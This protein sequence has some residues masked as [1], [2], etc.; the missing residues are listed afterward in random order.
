MTNIRHSRR[1]CLPQIRALGHTVVALRLLTAS[2]G[3]SADARGGK[4]RLVEGISGGCSSSDMA[5]CCHFFTS[6][7]KLL[8]VVPFSCPFKLRLRLQK[9]ELLSLRKDGMRSMMLSAL[10]ILPRSRMIRFQSLMAVCMWVCECINL[11]EEA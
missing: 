5:S 7:Q 10:T 9:S 3:E 6:V 2:M 8:A 4:S 1:R 11:A